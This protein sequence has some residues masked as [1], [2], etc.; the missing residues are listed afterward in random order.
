MKAVLKVNECLTLELDSSNQKELFE[1]LA[2][3]QEVFGEDRCGK[4][5]STDL[6]FIVRE[7]DG[8]KFYEVQC[9][10]CY[11][12]L[13]FGSHKKGETLFPKRKDGDSY[14]PDNGWTKWDREQ[15]KRV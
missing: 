15:Q 11:A 12:R 7:N 4:C 13:A 2:N 14:L 6:R 3:L 8:N 1:N 9:R 10:K 5:D